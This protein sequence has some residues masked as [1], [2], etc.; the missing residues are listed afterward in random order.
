MYIIIISYMS[1]SLLKLG[2]LS[3]SDLVE[4]YLF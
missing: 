4:Y 3:Y 2:K 1:K